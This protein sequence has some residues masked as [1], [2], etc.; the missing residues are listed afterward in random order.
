MRIIL[1]CLS[2]IWLASCSGGRQNRI[3][4]IREQEN[5]VMKSY[6]DIPDKS[7][8]ESLRQDYIAFA[9]DYPEDS[10][11]PK[12]LHKAAELALSMNMASDAIGTLDRLLSSYPDYTYRPDALFFKGFIQENHLKDIAAARKTYEDF[13]KQYPKHNLAK[14]VQFAT[15]H[16]GKSP[17]EL[18]NEFMERTNQQ[19]SLLSDSIK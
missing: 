16:L 7:T 2:L 4:E 5:I 3:D 6:D 14:Q 9:D 10:L 18:V 12:F 15:E 17:E 8:A 1:L 11:S 13:L 19:D